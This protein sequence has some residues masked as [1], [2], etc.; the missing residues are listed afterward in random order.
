MA[1]VF[2]KSTL[3]IDLYLPEWYLYL[4]TSEYWNQKDHTTEVNFS[5]IM[6]CFCYDSTNLSDLTFLCVDE[7][8]TPHFFQLFKSMYM[9]A[10]LHS[11]VYMCDCICECICMKCFNISLNIDATIIIHDCISSLFCIS[12]FFLM[13]FVINFPT[14]I[15]TQLFYITNMY[16]CS[17]Q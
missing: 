16:I 17:T 6:F 8:H 5:S 1:H 2:N 10:Y 9:H 14:R 12:F 11:Y 13:F 3:L 4:M 7:K 15:S